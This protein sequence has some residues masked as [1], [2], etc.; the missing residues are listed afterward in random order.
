MKHEE[1]EFVTDLCL[2]CGNI[3]RDELNKCKV[4]GKNN[5]KKITLVE[6]KQAQKE[7]KKQIKKLLCNKCLHRW[8]EHKKVSDLKGEKQ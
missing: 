1:I 8:E 2:N 4:C 6:K 3:R 5:W 7:Y